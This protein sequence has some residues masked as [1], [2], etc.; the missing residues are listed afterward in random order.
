M[1]KDKGEEEK[2]MGMAGQEEREAEAFAEIAERAL[3]YEPKS[4]LTKL[5]PLI[6][7]SLLDARL[8]S[9]V[10]LR[11]VGSLSLCKLMI[12]S[13]RFCEEHLQL[14]FSLLFPRA[15]SQALEIESSQLMMDVDVKQQGA[16]NMT[17]VL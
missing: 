17:M 13:R 9:S 4:L 1:A 15:K 16:G 11:R 12:V 7:G 8:R 10:I 5:K 6:L 3:L 2:D 14:L